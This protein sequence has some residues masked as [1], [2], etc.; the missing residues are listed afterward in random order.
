LQDLILKNPITK[1]GLEE[2]LKVKALSS[3]HSTAKTNKQT[4]NLKAFPI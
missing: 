3:N 4:K 1:I 2:W